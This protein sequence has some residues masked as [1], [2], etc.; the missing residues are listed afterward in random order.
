MNFQ[1]D[2]PVYKTHPQLAYLDSA[3]SSQK[4][5]CVIDSMTR[6]Y[7]SEYANVHRGVY[8]LS[9]KATIA[10]EDARRTVAEFLG[11]TEDG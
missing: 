10:F 6:M 8:R 3:A 11:A 7:Q 9:E 4:A 5:G 1:S 2:F